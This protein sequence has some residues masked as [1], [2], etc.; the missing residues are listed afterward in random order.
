MPGQQALTPKCHFPRITVEVRLTLA[1]VTKQ[2][3]AQ[4]DLKT[5]VKAASISNDL[6]PPREDDKVSG[7][8]GKRFVAHLHRQLQSD[9]YT[10]QPAEFIRVPKPGFSSRP[11]ALLTLTDRVVYESLVARVRPALA[12]F[13]VPEDIVLWPRAAVTPTRWK[14]FEHLPLQGKSSEYVVKADV[15]G[16]YD[17]IDHIRLSDRLI[18]ATGEGDVVDALV[19][20]LGLVMKNARGLPQGL[21][22]SDT[23]ATAYLQ[24]ID[25]AMVRSGVAYWRHGDDVR[26]RTGTMSSAR[27]AIAL[28]E[29][30]LRAQGLLLNSAKCTVLKI[31]T[32]SS[33]LKSTARAFELTEQKLLDSRIEEISSDSSAL[34]ATL[35]TAGLS[36]QLAWDLFY[37]HSISLEELLEQIG[38]H[39]QPTEIEVAELLFAQAVAAPPDEKDG[40]SKEQFHHQLVSSLL[41]LTAAKSTAGI[42]SCASLIARFPEKTEL[43]CRY[44]ES[45]MSVSAAAVVQQLENV[46]NSDAYYFTPWQQAWLI[47]TLGPGMHLSEPK[48]RQRLAGIANAARVHWIVRVEAMKALAWSNALEQELASDAWRTAPVAYR[49]D[50]LSA[51]ARM[52]KSEAWAERFVAVAHLDPVDKVVVDHLLARQSEN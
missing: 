38:E 49:P 46:L 40:L 43:F 44:L 22:P 45:L 12:K 8:L 32:Y 7:E 6:L 31:A 48:T 16:F 14:D 2:L 52:S 18:Y 20:F 13:L 47:R 39:I 42:S 27:E 17:S 24:P 11:A 29:D 3:V 26:I 34:T 23:L 1:L 10:P 50:V 35:E 51:V 37:H 41:R 4:L 30:E 9:S 5:A 28:F 36:S 19:A 15:S 21:L 25:A 33:E